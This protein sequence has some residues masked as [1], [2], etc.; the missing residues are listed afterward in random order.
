MQKGQIVSKIEGIEN[1]ENPELF[2]KNLEKYDIKNKNQYY[3]SSFAF[4]D[5]YLLPMTLNQ[6]VSQDE[7]RFVNKKIKGRYLIKSLTQQ[8]DIKLIDDLGIDIQREIQSVYGNQI[9]SQ[10]YQNGPYLVQKYISNPLLIN[11]RKFDWNCLVGIISTDPLI[12]IF[13]NGYTKYN[14]NITEFQIFEAEEKIKAAITYALLSV[15]DKIIDKKGQTQLLSVT[16]QLD[17][18]LDPFFIGVKNQPFLKD[19]TDIQ[20]QVFSD[21]VRDYLDAVLALNNLTKEQI[22]KKQIE[23]QQFI[24]NYVQRGFCKVLINEAGKTDYIQENINLIQ[25]WKVPYINQVQYSQ[26]IDT[27]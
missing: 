22:I 26:L 23:N 15:K 27:G 5:T 2:Y 13:N 1:W 11:K 6:S 17:E 18:N 12:V 25:S 19:Q 14:S 24:C 4:L 21:F 3:N 10:K 7:A 20:T 9:E 8:D 16:F